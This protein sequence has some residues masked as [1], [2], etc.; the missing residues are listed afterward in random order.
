MVLLIPYNQGCFLIADR[1]E[2]FRDGSKTEFTKL[3]LHGDNGPA[4]GCAGGADLI[5]KLYSE[6][7]GLDFSIQTP[8][9]SIKQKL[10]QS[11][12]EAHENAALI[13]PGLDPDRLKIDFF[14]IEIRN[15]EIDT[16]LF[17]RLW[18]RKIDRAKIHAIPEE[19]IAV[20]QY[21]IDTTSFSE[22]D[23]ISFGIEILRQVS[24][25]NVTVGPPE[26]HGYDMIKTTNSGKFS[27][28]SEPATFQRRTVNELLTEIKSIE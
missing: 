22:E 20:R 28:V 24:F 17:N 4:M 10:D 16:S 27:F 25:H 9:T 14:L 26:Y 6:L 23:A 7:R 11:I 2:T 13:G 18:I 19:N 15:N 21:L 12:K 8:S 3:Y 1:Q 5:R